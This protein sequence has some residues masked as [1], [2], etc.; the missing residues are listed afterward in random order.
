MWEE[1]GIPLLMET[2]KCIGNWWTASQ[3]S[4]GDGGGSVGNKMRL[5]RLQNKE[6]K[7]FALWNI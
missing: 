7:E 1:V 5:N 2:S 4:V 6:I 3:S